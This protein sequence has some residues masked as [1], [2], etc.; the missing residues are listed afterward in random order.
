MQLFAQPYK[1]GLLKETIS[2]PVAY[3]NL[4]WY[5]YNALFM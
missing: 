1:L 5:C 3:R 2:K 4:S